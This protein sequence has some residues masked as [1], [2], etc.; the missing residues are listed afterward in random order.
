MVV[1]G[2]W[3]VS[4]ERGTPVVVDLGCGQRGKAAGEETETDVKRSWFMISGLKPV[5]GCKGCGWKD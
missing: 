3:A 4:Y 5:L 1:L 2:G